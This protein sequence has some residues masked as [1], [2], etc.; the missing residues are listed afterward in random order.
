L[1][2]IELGT[3]PAFAAIDRGLPIAGQTGTLALRFA[4]TP[5]AG[6]L[7]A[8]TGHINGVVGLAGIVG[9]AD[10]DAGPRFAFVANGTFSTDEGER[11]QDEIAATVGAYPDAPTAAELVPAPQHPG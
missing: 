8:K 9:G 11:L 5:L 4:G 10:P 1:G 6:R 2:V 7:R 3:R